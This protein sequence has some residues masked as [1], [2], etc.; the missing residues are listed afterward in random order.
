MRGRGAICQ[1]GGVTSLPPLRAR[2]REEV[3]RSIDA[4]ALRLFGERGYD[5]VTTD[6]IASAA[7]VSPS[8]Y[9]RHVPTKDDL[10]LRPVRAS[11]AA[12]LERFRASQDSDPEA[13]LVAAIREQTQSLSDA[14]PANWRAI[15]AQVPG[16]L[17]RVQ[18]IDDDDR[19]QLIAITAHRL[20]TAEDDFRP[21]VLVISV[22]AVVEFG[23]RRWMT[24]GD[25]APLVDYID[26][27]LA[28]RNR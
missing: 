26:A 16:I 10:L 20:R 1:S 21:G 24:A 15:I 22:L 5:A 11:S 17:D 12:I 7:G 19:E 3:R 28:A 13:A 8:T 6:E 18:M 9:Y 27:A 14:E 4:A 2:Q 25:N 23:Y